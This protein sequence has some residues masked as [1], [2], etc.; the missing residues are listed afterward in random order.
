MKKKCQLCRAGRPP[1]NPYGTVT[2]TFS[3]VLHTNTFIDERRGLVGVDI[4]HESKDICV[5]SSCT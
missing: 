1:I 2:V 3:L 5:L 4:G